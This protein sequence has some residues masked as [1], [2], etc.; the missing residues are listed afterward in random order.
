MQAYSVTRLTYRTLLFRFKFIFGKNDECA[1]EISK[2]T[3]DDEGFYE[4]V[5]K[6]KSGKATS[7]CE[8]LVNGK[9]T[10]HFDILIVKLHLRHHHH[11]GENSKC[12]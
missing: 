9:I 8:L 1:L 10:F 4:C 12:S 2:V 5:A 7:K 11:V 3:V 6:N